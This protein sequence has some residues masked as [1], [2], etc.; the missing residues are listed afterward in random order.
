MSFAVV[1]IS[2]VSNV[3]NDDIAEVGGTLGCPSN[4][5]GEQKPRKN[6]QFCCKI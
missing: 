6:C 4:D 5:L 2:N 3:S 1:N